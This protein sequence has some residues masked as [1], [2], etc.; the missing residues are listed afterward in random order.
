[1]EVATGRLGKHPG[2]LG[3]NHR[4]VG[5]SGAPPSGDPQRLEAGRLGLAGNRLDSLDRLP[6]AEHVDV[7][8]G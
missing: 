7:H 6:A 5:E 2:R 1:M 3:G 4:T 8:C